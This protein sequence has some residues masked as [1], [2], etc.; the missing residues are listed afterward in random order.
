MHN[1]IAVYPAD[2]EHLHDLYSSTCVCHPKVEVIGATL[3][4]THN[5]LWEIILPI[6][7]GETR[8]KKIRN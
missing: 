5:R 3:I 7:E 4:Y 8:Y 6:R 1:D 2:E